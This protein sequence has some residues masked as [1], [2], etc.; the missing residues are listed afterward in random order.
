MT[1]ICFSV[2]PRKRG[3]TWRKR[4]RRAVITKITKRALDALHPDASARDIWIWHTGDGA[5]KGFGV[6]MK[7]S[8][9]ASYL[10]QYRTKEGRTRWLVLV[11]IREMTPD[12]TRELAKE[13]LHAVR[14]GADPSAARRAARQS[15]TVAELCDLYLSEGRA[16]KK[17]STLA[18]DK[19]RIKRHIKPLIGN[20]IA[21]GHA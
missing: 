17:A 5:F 1:R 16:T 19:G 20:S 15:I 12:Q 13:K 6:R 4:S 2:L 8:G 11:R 9:D 21:A 18:T 14:H 10:V 7:P 3:S